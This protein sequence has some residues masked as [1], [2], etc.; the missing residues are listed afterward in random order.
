MVKLLIILGILVLLLLFWPI[1]LVPGLAHRRQLAHLRRF[2]YAHRGLH[3]RRNGIPENSLAAFSRAANLGYG[4]ELDVH[5]TADG[6]L[7]VM[8]DDGLK[9]TCGVDVQVHEKTM[10]E[11]K[12]CRLEGT[13]ERI[14]EFRE[15]L[16]LVDGRVP[17]IIE[18]KTVKGNVDAICTAVCRELEG[19]RGMY[20]VES[21]D[22]RV[23]RW[24][25]KRRPDI[26]RGQLAEHFRRH[27]TMVNPVGDFLHHNLFANILTRPDFIAYQH[28]DRHSL[29]L[30]LCRKLYG[31][32]EFNWTVKDK[33]THEKIRKDGG[34]VIFEDFLPEKRK[35][36]KG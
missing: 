24:L 22:P 32:T 11:L 34:I 30:R 31:V 7:A 36:K 21:F 16:E 9:R 15:V 18:I 6:R 14:P 17:L 10:Q 35:E 1:S 20:C 26:V 8:H 25:R 27:G 13:E 23:V 4:M 29:S 33:E 12:G 5:L 2:D 28:K 19:Y 3:D